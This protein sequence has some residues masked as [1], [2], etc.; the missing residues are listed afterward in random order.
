MSNSAA[1]LSSIDLQTRYAHVFWAR[2]HKEV[3]SLCFFCRSPSCGRKPAEVK[4]RALTVAGRLPKQ[5]KLS[6]AFSPVPRRA[7]D[8]QS[9]PAARAASRPLLFAQLFAR[10]RVGHGTTGVP[11][12]I[13]EHNYVPIHAWRQRTDHGRLSG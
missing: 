6:P 1:A 8:I 2:R 11:P 5:A 13:K 3:A 4:C 10:L 7:R 12:D 9:A